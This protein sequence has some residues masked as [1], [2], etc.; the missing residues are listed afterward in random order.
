MKICRF[1]DNR[2]GLID[3]AEVIDV[4]EVLDH[5]PE[6]RWPLPFGDPLI[7]NLQSLAPH[8]RDAASR[9]A[10]LSLSSVQ[11]RSPV[12]TPSKI[13]AAPGNY[14]KHVEI[15]TLDPGVDHGFHRATM[16]GVERPV[17]SHGLFL[18][19]CSSLVGPADGVTL[20]W[21]D[22]ERRV[23]HEVE[24][25]VVIGRKAWRVSRE[26]ALDYVAGYAIGVDFTVR[27]TED[28]SFRKSAESFAL[29][30]PWLTTADEI[31]D[32]TDISFWLS[33]DGEARQSSSTR[34]ITVDL[35]ELIEI[36]S[37]VYVLHPGDIIMTG[38][39]EGVGPLR[40]GQT[41]KAGAA[42]I[43]EMEIAVHGPPW[44]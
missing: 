29:L 12:A 17:D 8:I 22:S 10:R 3:G 28:R 30:G 43:G 31:P 13:I 37:R 40:V 15:D 44:M 38:T 4:T 5:L 42:G 7:A 23:D 25:A 6:L 20:G 41:V 32:P 26:E 18:K 39:P 1:D 27:G 35:A 21:P 16:I 14:R 36:A 33:V 19:A 2:L 24:I 9:G 11:L 34:E